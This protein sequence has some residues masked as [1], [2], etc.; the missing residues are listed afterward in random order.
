MTDTG[1]VRSLHLLAAVLLVVAASSVLTSCSAMIAL[2][3]PRHRNL[4]VIE[5]G[6]PRKRAVKELGL[7]H[8]SYRLEDGSKVD[9]WRFKQGDHLAW[10]LGRA[11]IYVIVGVGTFGFSEL[12]TTPYE[13]FRKRPPRT[14]VVEYDPDERVRGTMILGRSGFIEQQGRPSAISGIDPMTVEPSGV[15]PALERSNA[16]AVIA[17]H[18]GLAVTKLSFQRLSGR[19]EVTGPNVENDAAVRAYVRELCTSEDGLVLG[20]RTDD[21]PRDPAIKLGKVDDD[22]DRRVVFRCPP[23]AKR[24]GVMALDTPRRALIGE[25]GLPDASARA[26]DGSRVDVWDFDLGMP[27]DLKVLTGM[28]GRGAAQTYVVH[29]G[30]DDRISATTLMTLNGW[31]GQRG[32]VPPLEHPAILAAS[33]G[34]SAT[35]DLVRERELARIAARH[36]IGVTMLDFDPRSD[37]GSAVLEGPGAAGQRT[38][39]AYVTEMCTAR[40]GLLARKR[41]RPTMP[42]VSV[43]AEWDAGRWRVEYRCSS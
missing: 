19:V 11:L 21:H 15:G 13:L 27:Q 24:L 18:H 29:Y 31:L 42:D 34:S 16:L 12:G 23:P 36:G 20:P 39:E 2:S 33:V 1:G 22:G 4:D 40:D 37:G 28:S 6:A 32:R 30:T 9:V 7:P 26:E 10:R 3:K 8:G 41:D 5:P 17:E 25:F 14:Y 38:I 35:R 43:T